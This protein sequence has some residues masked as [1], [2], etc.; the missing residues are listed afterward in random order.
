[1][2]V[3]YM[4]A[5]EAWY[6][7]SYMDIGEYGF[8]T[9]SSAPQPGTDCPAHAAF[10][11]ATL[12]GED[13][14]PVVLPGVIC[15]FERNTGSPAWRHA[16]ITDQTHEGRPEVELVVRSIPAIGNYD[17]IMDWVF[18]TR[19][20]IRI[21]VGATGMDAVR[22]VAARNM[23]DPSAAVETQAGTLVAPGAVGIWHD[24]YISFRLGLDV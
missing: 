21:D 12:A 11:D 5:S 6:W 15:V 17:Y 13:G 24:H 18:T 23:A 19:G 9:L 2:F 1:M 20:E 7:R 3:P 4:D 16:E 8:G 14:K 22:G 10:L